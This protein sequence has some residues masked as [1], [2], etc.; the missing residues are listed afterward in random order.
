MTEG[1]TLP[2]VVGESLVDLSQMDP[3]LSKRMIADTQKQLAIRAAALKKKAL[4]EAQARAVAIAPF[5]EELPP[6][7]KTETIPVPQYTPVV[8]FT[9]PDRPA[10]QPTGHS[11]VVVRRG[12][13]WGGLTITAEDDGGGDGG[14]GILILLLLL[15]FMIPPHSESGY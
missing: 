1:D 12:G 7:V 5:V 15:A 8:R 9:L 13:R 11:R 4:A 14:A 10:R 2:V 3:R 6:R